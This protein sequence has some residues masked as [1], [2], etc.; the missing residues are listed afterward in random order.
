MLGERMLSPEV[1]KVFDAYPKAYRAGMLALRQLIFNVAS[2]IDDVGEIEETLKWGEWSYL[3][4]VSKSGSTI[5]IDWKPSNPN[6]YAVYFRCQTNLVEQFRKD[7]P[8]QFHFE[9]NRALMFAVDAPI[10]VAPLSK[11]IATGLTYHRDKR[12]A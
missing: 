8:D 7:F 10:P 9:G 5:R 1:K 6:V 2:S 3:T 12:N 11:C 4:T